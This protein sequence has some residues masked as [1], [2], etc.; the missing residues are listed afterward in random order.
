VLLHR[1][2]QAAGGDLVTGEA[3]LRAPPLDHAVDQRGAAVDHA[4]L[5]AV[6]INYG[7]NVETLTDQKAG[8]LDIL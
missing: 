4:G 6:G 7:A 5:E 8:G 1:A 2:R 3:E